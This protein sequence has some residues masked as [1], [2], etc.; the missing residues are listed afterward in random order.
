M[1]GSVEVP[2]SRFRVLRFAAAMR[3]AREFGLDQATV[4]AIALDLDP[5]GCNV[6]RL[7]DLLAIALVD[8][9][10]L[11]LPQAI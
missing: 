6:G 11:R 10:A 4:N 1:A 5:T 9:D 7:I 3:A 8:K 2:G